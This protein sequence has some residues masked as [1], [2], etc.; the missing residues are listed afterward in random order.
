MYTIKKFVKKSQKGNITNRNLRV[1]LFN[2]SNLLA[3]T[4]VRQKMY[5]ATRI[6]CIT[7][8]YIK[9]VF[10]NSS[11]SLYCEKYHSNYLRNR[12]TTKVL[13]LQSISYIHLKYNLF[14]N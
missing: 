8:E 10:R 3:V 5:M 2:I 4:L 13:H 1:D 7:T 14:R 12:F 11:H 6:N 9:I